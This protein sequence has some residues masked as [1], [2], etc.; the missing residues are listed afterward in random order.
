MQLFIY[1][2]VILIKINIRHYYVY[3]FNKNCKNYRRSPGEWV[4]FL[5]QKNIA[6]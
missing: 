6:V 2:F 3:N 1:T 5:I 4:H